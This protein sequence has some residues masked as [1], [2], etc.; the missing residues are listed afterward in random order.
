MLNREISYALLHS[1]ATANPRSA[2]TGCVSCVARAQGGRSRP[3]LKKVH[4]EVE[5]G[6]AKGGGRCDEVARSVKESPP[7]LER[8]KRESKLT[9]SLEHKKERQNRGNQNDRST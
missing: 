6:V 3:E 4:A 9:F 7:A 5:G 1:H 2:V 8:G